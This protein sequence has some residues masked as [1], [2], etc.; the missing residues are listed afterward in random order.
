MKSIH[1]ELKTE[2]DVRAYVHRL[3]H[4]YRQ[5]AL[6][7]IVNAGL[8]LVWL[9]SGEGYFWPIWVIIAWGIP[10]FIQAIDLKLPPK[11]IQDVVC[12]IMHALPFMK[13]GWEDEQV[14]RI[15]KS[16]KGGKTEEPVSSKASVAAASK[17]A[18]KKAQPS[19][20]K[21]A[22][23]KKPVAKKPAAVSTK[24]KK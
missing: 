22:A 17:P 7:A 24:K 15:L 2:N 19:A 4:F 1:H 14:D 23:P 5:L 16:K 9:L 3:G 12:T 10:L 13:S 6:Y 18:E 20:P 21:K 11:P 8:I